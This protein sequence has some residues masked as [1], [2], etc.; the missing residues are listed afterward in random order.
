MSS[1]PQQDL[2]E[3][4][5]FEILEHFADNMSFC[6][7]SSIVT[8][9]LRGLQSDRILPGVGPKVQ[10]VPLVFDI[11]RSTNQALIFKL[12]LGSKKCYESAYMKLG[13]F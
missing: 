2:A 4:D 8:R 13:M 7:N 1:T 10:H 9:G 3:L 11:N 5:E 6:S 12:F